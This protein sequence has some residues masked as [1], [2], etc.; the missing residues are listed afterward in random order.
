[1]LCSFS[2]HF[3]KIPDSRQQ[4]KICY[5]LNEI[6]FLTLSAV[7]SDCTEWQ[8]IVDFGKDK[9]EWLRKYYPFENGIPSHD[10]INRTLSLIDTKAF[11]DVFRLW[12]TENLKLPEGTLVNLD[13]KKLRASATKMEQQT[14]RVEGGKGAVHLLEAWCNDFGLCLDI[15][16]VDEKENEIKAIP[17]VLNHLDISGCMVSIDAIGCQKEI[18]SDICSRNADYTI[19][20]KKNQPKLYHAIES[21]F[22]KHDE[23]LVDTDT[24]FKEHTKDHGRAEERIC[25]VISSDCIEDIKIKESWG[26]LKSLIRIQSKRYVLATQKE[27][28][29]VRYYIGSAVKTA[30]IMASYVREHWG[31]ENRLHWSLDVY[32]GEDFSR[33]QVNN[34]AANFG[35]I[36]RAAHNLMKT[37]DEKI[38]I[39][40]KLKKCARSDEYRQG[41]L[42]I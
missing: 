1:L 29:E 22:I 32:W 38:S 6:F 40:R 36:L 31:I 7:I 33:K 28:A 25:T 30:K 39:K 3:D 15:E 17:V 8:E 19:G 14:S 9:L 24:R 10:T 21:A 18:T 26:T 27:S 34:I 12:T 13:G 2:S 16:E 35:I 11:G 4:A 42:R 23:L 37:A 41:I 20:V 5:P